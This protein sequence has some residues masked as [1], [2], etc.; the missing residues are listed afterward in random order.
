MEQ[1]PE[2]TVEPVRP[3]ARAQVMLPVFVPFSLIGGLLPSFSLAANLY[4]LALGG[5]MMLAGMSSRLPRRAAPAGLLPGVAW[6]LVPVVVFA[7]VEVITFAM[8][9]T[10]DYPTLSLLADPLLDGYLLRSL[11]YFG[12]LAGFWGLVR[13]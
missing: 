7:V 9:S 2:L 1:R 6:W 3:W 4:V 13:R 12:W 8:G 5:G 11:A 10:H